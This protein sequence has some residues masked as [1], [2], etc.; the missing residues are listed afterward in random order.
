MKCHKRMHEKRAHNG[1]QK[2]GRVALYVALQVLDNP[3]KIANMRSCEH[4]TNQ[5]EQIPSL[6]KTMK[7]KMKLK[8]QRLWA[9]SPSRFLGRCRSRFAPRPNFVVVPS[10]WQP[11][12]SCGHRS[13]YVVCLSN[14]I[15]KYISPFLVISRYSLF[16]V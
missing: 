4:T 1:H 13:L 14:H 10:S 8:K 9:V 11:S 15:C 2:I 7:L 12:S 5:Q 6:H 3:I 16:E